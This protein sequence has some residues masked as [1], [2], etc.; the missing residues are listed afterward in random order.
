M[1]TVS[2][3]SAAL[4]LGLERKELLEWLRGLGWVNRHNQPF[5]HIRQEGLMGHTQKYY[6]HP[7]G[8][9]VPARHKTPLLTRAGV[10]EL[11]RLRPIKEATV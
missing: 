3:D 4:E 2:M 7:E 8:Y 10:T 6:R 5:F 1:R 9:W 11:K